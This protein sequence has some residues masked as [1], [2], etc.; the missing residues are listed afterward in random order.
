MAG[1]TPAGLVQKSLKSIRRGLRSLVLDPTTDGAL[2]ELVHA[3]RTGGGPASSP[4]AAPPPGPS[5]AEQQAR[6]EAR[7]YLERY[8]LPLR[9]FFQVQDDL[10]SMIGADSYYAREYRPWEH[11][12]EIAVIDWVYEHCTRDRA[13]LGKV[14]DIGPAY[15]TFLAFVRRLCPDAE[16]HAYDLLETYMPPRLPVRDRIRCH[17]GNIELDAFPTDDKFDLIRFTEV[18]EHLNFYAA[19]T[20]AKIGSLLTPDGILYMTTPNRTHHGLRDKYYPSHKAF[21]KPVDVPADFT[22]VDDH[23]WHWSA[24]EIEEV[25]AEAGVEVVRFEAVYSSLDGPT[26]AHLDYALRR[27][28]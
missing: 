26:G 9:M 8:G 7:Y 6:L 5:P 18:L 15:G 14:L 2:R 22:W 4:A 28:R 13:T 12:R 20:L 17:R 1:K 25:V 11:W 24:P 23:T 10:V 21:P 3:H 16:L 19:P 27:R